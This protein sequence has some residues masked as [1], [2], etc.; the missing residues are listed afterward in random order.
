MYDSTKIAETIKK[1][2]KEKSIIIKTMLSD[3]GLGSNTMSAMYHGKSL[4]SDSLAKIADYLEVTVDYLLGREEVSNIADKYELEDLSNKILNAYVCLKP[5]WRDNVNRF[6]Q[7]VADD[8]MS[9]SIQKAKEGVYDKIANCHAQERVKFDLHREVSSV[10]Y[11]A[12]AYVDRIGVEPLPP[13]QQFE[14]NADD[15]PKLIK[16]HFGD[17]AAS[18][19][20]G[21]DIDYVNWDVIEVPESR[22]AHSADYAVKVTGDSMIPDFSNDDVVLIRKQ[23]AVYEGQ[24]GLFTHDGVTYIKKFGSDRLISLNEEYDDIMLNEDVQFCCHGLVLGK[25]KT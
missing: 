17:M 5:E 25:I 2:A 3:C 11:S 9:D 12:F 19:G 23:P 18:A 13:I 15:L 22:E 24:I 21:S 6:L 8:I 4:A 14:E 16:I 7:I 20:T 10:F 1:T